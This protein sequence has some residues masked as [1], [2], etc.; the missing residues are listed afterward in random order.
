MTTCWLS[1]VEVEASRCHIVGIFDWNLFGKLMNVK[2]GNDCGNLF[3][4]LSQ[5]EETEDEKKANCKYL[6][7]VRANFTVCCEYPV[8]VIWMWQYKICVKECKAQD[9]ANE[10]CCILPCCFRFLGVLNITKTT[11]PETNEEK[12]TTD[13]DWNG[14]VYSFLLSVGNDTRWLPVVTDSTSRCYNDFSGSNDEIDCDVIPRSLYTVIDCAYVENYVKCP[15]FNPAGLKECSYTMQYA[16]K[17]L[18]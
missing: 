7:S 4:V 16:Q 10:R 11:D 2:C 9:R 3:Q 12:V 1:N 5:E 6:N 8:L 15:V 14:L 13:V 18:N 17:C